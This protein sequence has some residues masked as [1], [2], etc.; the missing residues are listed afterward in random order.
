MEV[1]DET[2]ATDLFFNSTTFA[3]LENGNTQLHKLSWQEIY[4]ML[5]LELK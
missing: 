4:K 5:K 1:K 3:K 2:L